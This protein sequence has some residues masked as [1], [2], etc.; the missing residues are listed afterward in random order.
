ME[1]ISRA[2]R[3]NESFGIHLVSVLME[4]ISRAHRDNKSSCKCSSVSW[5]ISHMLIGTMSLLIWLVLIGTISPVYHLDMSGG[6]IS[7]AYSSGQLARH[8]HQDN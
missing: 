4:T 3:N 6:T 8:T 7:P 5:T 1:T 2:H